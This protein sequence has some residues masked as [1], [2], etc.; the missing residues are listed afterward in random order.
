MSG[1]VPPGVAGDDGEVLREYVD[2]FALTLVA[3]LRADDHRSLAVLQ[4]QLREEDSRRRVQAR[5]SPGVAHTL[6]RKNTAPD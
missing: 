3:P 2:D 6:A 5:G 4:F 1:I